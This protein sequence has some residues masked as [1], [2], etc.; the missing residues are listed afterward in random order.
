MK[1]DFTDN[2]Y[3]SAA[4]TAAFFI[5]REIAYRHRSSMLNRSCF[6]L[7]N[8]APSHGIAVQYWTINT[9]EDAEYLLS[10]GAYGIITDYP[11]MVYELRERK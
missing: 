5:V 6:L 1:K 3:F 8:Y 10:I 7:L 4:L 2:P 11:D 9:Q